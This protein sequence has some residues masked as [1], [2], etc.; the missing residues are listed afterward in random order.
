[1]VV[2]LTVIVALQGTDRAMEL[3]RYPGEEVC[4]SGDSV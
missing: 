1:V 3:G 4:E 2:E